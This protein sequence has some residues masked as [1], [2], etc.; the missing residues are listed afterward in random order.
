MA[1]QVVPVFTSSDQNRSARLVFSQHC[2]YHID[3]R[4]VLSLHYTILP[5]SV[6]SRELML[7]AFF[8]KIFLHLKILEFRF[9]V[10]P[11]ILIF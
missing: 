10:A 9:I 6:G 11:Y 4:L 5:W 3:E 7:D 2:P 8:L 1:W